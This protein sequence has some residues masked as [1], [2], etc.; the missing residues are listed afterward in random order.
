MTLA[1]RNSRVIQIDGLALR[2]S[3]SFDSGFNVLVAH[4]RDIQGQQ[5]EIVVDNYERIELD[6]LSSNNGAGN[7]F[8]FQPRHVEFLLRK[9]LAL[10]WHPERKGQAFRWHYHGVDP[11]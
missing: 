4:H 10:G 8:V 1:R 6:T 11:A 7:R 2:W 3:Y 9:A 5:V